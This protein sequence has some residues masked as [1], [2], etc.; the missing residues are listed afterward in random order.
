MSEPL[1]PQA[2]LL[3]E[4]HESARRRPIYRDTRDNRRV[5]VIYFGNK[6]YRITVTHW[7]PPEHPDHVGE[8]HYLVQDGHLTE[9]APNGLV[10]APRAPTADCAAYVSNAVKAALGRPG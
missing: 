1:D 9:V 7:G 2:L 6:A 8:M 4:Q 5:M 10:A 3:L